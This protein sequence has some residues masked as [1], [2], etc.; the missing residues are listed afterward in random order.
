MDFQSRREADSTVMTI[1][2]DTVAAAIAALS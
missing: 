1:L 2:D